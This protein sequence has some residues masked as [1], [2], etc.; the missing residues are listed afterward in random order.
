M[1]DDSPIFLCEG[2]SAK[3]KLIPS[4]ELSGIT[5]RLPTTARNDLRSWVI[6]PLMRLPVYAT[7]SAGELTVRMADDSGLSTT[8]YPYDEIHYLRAERFYAQNEIMYS[9]ELRTAWTNVESRLEGVLEMWF[10]WTPSEKLLKSWI[11]TTGGHA[12]GRTIRPKDWPAEAPWR[13]NFELHDVM[14]VKN[15]WFLKN[16]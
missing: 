5:S 12:A 7:Y 8:L 1:E 15:S 6:F 14:V 13:A 10:E 9:E 11:L 3:I 16:M 4:E 2:E